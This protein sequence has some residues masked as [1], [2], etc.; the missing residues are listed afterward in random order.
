MKN[1]TT[2]RAE[3]KRAYKTARQREGRV[4]PP[5]GWAARQ[6]AA[7]HYLAT[8]PKEI[9]LVVMEARRSGDPLDR[10]WSWVQIERLICES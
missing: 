8:T 5:K 3:F 4:G 7:G 2:T 1:R 6:I 9:A 10:R